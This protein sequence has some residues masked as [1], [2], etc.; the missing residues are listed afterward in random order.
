M[1]QPGQLVVFSGPSGV[2][3]TTLLAEVFRRARQPLVMSVSATTRPPRAGEK[4]GK[5]YY[6][7]SVED[8]AQR[9]QRGEFLEC[10][11]VFGRGHWYGTLASEVA[12]RLAAGKWVVLEIDVDGAE[13]VLQEYP[14][15]LTI[16]IAPESIDVLE[17]RL[18][19]RGTESEDA[20][21]RRLEVAR[22]ELDRAADYRFH[23]VNDEVDRAAEEICA[24][25]DRQ[26]SADSSGESDT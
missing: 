5:H 18:R 26:A 15:A 24:F 4:E 19:G 3:K 10:S 9:R 11:E 8:F 17:R 13:Q 6:F 14:D 12:P 20:I 7:L 25:L 16:F 22:R 23:V 2:G 1:T 21:A